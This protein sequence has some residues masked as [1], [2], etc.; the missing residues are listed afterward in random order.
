MKDIQDSGF[1]WSIPNKEDLPADQNVEDYIY[2]K[3]LKA[4]EVITYVDSEYLV[5]GIPK[6][7]IIGK[8]TYFSPVVEEM[9]IACKGA[10]D[11]TA[12][13]SDLT[14][15]KVLDLR[16]FDMSD[17]ELMDMMFFA[18]INLANLDTS[19]CVAKHIK[20]VKSMF[21]DCTRL[22]C[23]NLNGFYIS[24][25]KSMERMFLGCNKLVS[26]EHKFTNK[27]VENV[28][29]MFA[30]CMNLIEINLGNV[31][32][33]NCKSMNNILRNCNSLVELEL[34][35]INAEILTEITKDSKKLETVNLSYPT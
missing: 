8:E 1:T 34:N 32:L 14:E 18:C 2:L 30:E 11:C 9:K 3:V 4:D 12:L 23:I 5:N 17:I 29:M 10:I 31:S 6:K 35:N 25:V 19:N 28:E 22:I 27:I 16:N 7:A 21:E 33:A 26:I 20:S 15:L 24:N 13:F